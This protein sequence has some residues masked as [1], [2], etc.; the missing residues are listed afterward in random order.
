MSGDGRLE[1]VTSYYD[2]I[3]NHK[4]NGGPGAGVGVAFL[5]LPQDRE[6][7]TLLYESAAANALGWNDPSVEIR[8]SATGLVMARELGDHDRGGAALRAAAEREYD[9]RYFGG[10]DEKFGWWFGLTTRPTRAASAAR[11]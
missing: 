11:A 8:A 5:L 3:V 9:P 10:H 7:A 1:W 6:T 2:P 4:A